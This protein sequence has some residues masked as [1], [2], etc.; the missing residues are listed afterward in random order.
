M[1]LIIEAERMSTSDWQD[2]EDGHKPN[3]D[4]LRISIS[5]ENVDDFGTNSGQ[6][7]QS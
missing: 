1:L 5:E 7:F 2:R 3:Y 4:S 6:E